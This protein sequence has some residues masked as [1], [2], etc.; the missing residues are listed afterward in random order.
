[1]VQKDDEINLFFTILVNKTTIDSFGLF[2]DALKHFTVFLM[3]YDLEIIILLINGHIFLVFFI[4]IES[5]TSLV[6]VDNH[7]IHN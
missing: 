3:I 7:P 5:Y 6:K 1:M 4:I 2:G